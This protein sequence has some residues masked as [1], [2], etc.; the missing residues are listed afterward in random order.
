[1]MSHA[2]QLVTLKVVRQAAVYHGLAQ[3]INQSAPLTTQG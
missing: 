1:M 3:L 2:G